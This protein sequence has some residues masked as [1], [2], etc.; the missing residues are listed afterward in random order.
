[1]K[2]NTLVTLLV[3]LAL[4]IGGYAL[5]TFLR[6]KEVSVP[7][8][9]FPPARLLEAEIDRIDIT[10]PAGSLILDKTAQGWTVDGFAVASDT[11]ESFWTALKGSAVRAVVARNPDN[12][13]TFAVDDATGK[14]VTFW[15]GSDKRAEVI[16]GKAADIGGTYARLSESNDVLDVAGNLSSAVVT[17]RDDW[18]D[19][20]I[21]TLDGST[22]ARM[23]LTQ[24]TKKIPLSKKDAVWVFSDR[25]DQAVNQ[26]NIA[27][28]ISAVVSLRAD[29]F[30]AADSA[31]VL[32]PTYF[33]ELFGSDN[34]PHATLS[35]TQREN[36]GAFVER[37]DT[38]TVFTIS[39]AVAQQLI[40]QRADFMAET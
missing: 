6:D 38:D 37:I 15:S 32:K 24:E 13:A 9:D 18:R 10:S 12:H 3:L 36:G 1:M 4:V 23:E 27:A 34:V 33:I 40:K 11:L 14:R 29:G 22:I 28:F 2:T 16:V 21:L 39:A 19:K 35:L 17:A 8:G 20:A 5:T 7:K 31:E 30:R 25:D 26:T